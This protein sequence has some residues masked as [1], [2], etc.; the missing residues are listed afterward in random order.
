MGS[1]QA[2]KPDFFISC[3][4]KLK[5]IFY[6]SIHKPTEILFMKNSSFDFIFSLVFLVV[7]LAVVYIGKFAWGS[8]QCSSYAELTDRETKY[9]LSNGCF[10]KHDG[11]YIPRSELERRFIMDK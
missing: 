2:N 8:Y 3:I 1:N 10:V 9:T 7:V 5:I 11:K 6:I 4:A